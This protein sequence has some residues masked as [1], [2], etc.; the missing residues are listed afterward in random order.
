MIGFEKHGLAIHIM[1]I[2]IYITLEWV[3]GD[4]MDHQTFSIHVLNLYDFS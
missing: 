2:P 3:A 4:L 1:I